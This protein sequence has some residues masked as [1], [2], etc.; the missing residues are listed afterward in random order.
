MYVFR[1]V[2]KL[3]V[4]DVKP[5]LGQLSRPNYYEVQFGGLGADLTG[6]L[7]SR[8]VSPR[9]TSGDF[10][11]LCYEAVLPGSSLG[12][13][14]SNNFHG[15]TENFAYQKIY[16]SLSLSFYCDNEYRGLKFLEH[17]MEYVVSGNRTNITSYAAGDYN[18]RLRYPDEYKSNAT[19]IFKFENDYDRVMEYSMLGLFPKDLSSTQLRYGPNSELTRI[20]CSFTYDR[21]IAGSINSYAGIL[22]QDNNLVSTLRD[23]TSG[24]PLRLINRVIN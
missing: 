15:V 9:F 2:R 10:G 8:G 1:V 20:S 14:Q 6:F 13:V 12:D 19:K 3:N 17:W 18:Y 7:A 11:L 24:D 4:A 21:Y 23:L 22:G 16:S 5:L